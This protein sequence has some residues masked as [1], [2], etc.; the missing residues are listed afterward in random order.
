VHQVFRRRICSDKKKQE[1]ALR[2]ERKR[3]QKPICC[4]NAPKLRIIF[5][6]EFLKKTAVS[7][8]ILCRMC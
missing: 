1:N 7:L 4:E 8:D 2:A 3:P 6:E 5:S